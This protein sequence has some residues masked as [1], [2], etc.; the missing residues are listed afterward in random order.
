[1]VNRAKPSDWLLRVAFETED[2]P[3][4]LKPVIERVALSIAT[5]GMQFIG[6]LSDADLEIVAGRNRLAVDRF[7]FLDGVSALRPG[8]FFRGAWFHDS[9]LPFST[10]DILARIIHNFTAAIADPLLRQAYGSRVRLLKKDSCASWMPLWLHP[11][12][13]ESR[14]RRRRCAM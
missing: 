2:F 8:R 3:F 4:G 7:L 6:P 13:S 11:W 14:M 1:M 5:L 10:R 12:S 9:P